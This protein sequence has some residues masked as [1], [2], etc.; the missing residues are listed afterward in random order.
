MIAEDIVR[1]S[2]K[3]L[4]DL[5]MQMCLGFFDKDEVEGWPEV[6]LFRLV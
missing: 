3:H 6:S 4:L 5:S 2:N 1:L